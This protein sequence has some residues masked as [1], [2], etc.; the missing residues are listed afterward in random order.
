ML[1]A[2]VNI[3][4]LRENASVPVHGSAGAAGADLKACL[5]EQITVEPG[6]NRNDTHRPCC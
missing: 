3:K 4:K 1:K 5:D 6:K 2:S